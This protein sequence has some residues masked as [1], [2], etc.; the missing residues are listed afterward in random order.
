MSAPEHQVE[1][2]SSVKISTTAKGDA[3]VEVK[4]YVETEDA[5]LNLARDQAIRVYSE[6]VQRV[7]GA[8]A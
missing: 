6:T 5:E 3:T 8:A 1:S 2:R 4:V 7:R